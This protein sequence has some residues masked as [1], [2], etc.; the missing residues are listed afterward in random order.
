MTSIDVKLCGAAPRDVIV[1]R[2]QDTV[3]SDQ[4]GELPLKAIPKPKVEVNSAHLEQRT[5][6]DL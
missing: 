4:H 5:P 3:T 2:L 6:S 1:K